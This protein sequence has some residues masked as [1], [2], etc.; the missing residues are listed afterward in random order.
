MQFVSHELSHYIANHN[1]DFYQYHL[2]KKRYSLLYTLLSLYLHDIAIIYL[3][4]P[5][6]RPGKRLQKT[7]WNIT[8]L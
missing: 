5:G 7:N 2:T 8:M 6:T 4:Y 3:L 1:A